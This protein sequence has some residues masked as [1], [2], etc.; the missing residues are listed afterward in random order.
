M[1]FARAVVL[2]MQQQQLIRFFAWDGDGTGMG[3]RN[4]RDKQVFAGELI[5]GGE[6]KGGRVQGGLVYVQQLLCE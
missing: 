3:R 2:D 1:A 4:L 6:R 5:G